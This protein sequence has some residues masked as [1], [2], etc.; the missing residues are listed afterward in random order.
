MKRQQATRINWRMLLALAGMLVL[1]IVLWHTWF[2]YPLRMLV[3][4]FHELSHGLMALATGGRIDHIEL[5][6]LEG[7]LCVCQGGILP[8]V[9]SAG[10][11][12]SLLWGGAI[13]L[14]ASYT[15]WDNGVCIFL[16]ALLLL[17]ALLWVRPVLSFGFIFTLLIG[18]GLVM[19]GWKLHNDINDFI[20][21]VIGLTSIL[22]VP[23]DIFSDTLARPYLP[24]DAR[25]LAELTHVPTMVWGF[26][27]LS[28]ACAAG[29]YFLVLAA[30]VPDKPPE[31]PKPKPR[32]S[33]TALD[34]P[35]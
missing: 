16:G 19:I 28:I 34:P 1:I 26:I 30:R 22:Y 35:L 6:A 9:A 25:R 21:K 29:A 14:T 31:D 32:R 12:G 18:A 4:F 10:Y 8:L 15:R 24:S 3:V 13:L 27:W 2:I 11:L 7:G 17:V 5:L 33:R 23:M 20:L